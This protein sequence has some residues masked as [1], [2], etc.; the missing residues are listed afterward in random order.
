MRTIATL[1]NHLNKSH[2]IYSRILLMSVLNSKT[3][4]QCRVRAKLAIKKIPIL[5]L[6]LNES[7]VHDSMASFLHITIETTMTTCNYECLLRHEKSHKSHI[8][9]CLRLLIEKKKR[10]VLWLIFWS[11]THIQ[12]KTANSLDS[13]LTERCRDSPKPYTYWFLMSSWT[14]HISPCLSNGRLKYKKKLV[15]MACNY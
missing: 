11:R 4:T 7:Q 12:T 10:I 1:R 14:R 2:I 5:V 15:H 8:E 9:M 13:W 3:A 6:V